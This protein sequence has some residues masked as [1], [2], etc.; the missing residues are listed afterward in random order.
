MSAYFGYTYITKHCVASFKEHYIN[1]I[2]PN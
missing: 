2:A 1:Q